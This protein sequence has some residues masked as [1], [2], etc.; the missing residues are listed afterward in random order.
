M[1]SDLSD[2][3]VLGS[4]NKKQKTLNTLRR[5]LRCPCIL[6][7]CRLTLVGGREEEEGEKKKNRMIKGR[8]KGKAGMGETR[9]KRG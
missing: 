8:R 4:K 7:E 1:L 5:N 6:R 2:F 3:S 9:D